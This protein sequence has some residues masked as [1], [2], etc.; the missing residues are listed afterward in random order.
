[1]V[2]KLLGEYICIGLRLKYNK[3]RIT[4]NHMYIKNPVLLNW[5]TGFLYVLTSELFF[6]LYGFIHGIDRSVFLFRFH[7]SKIIGNS[8]SYCTTMPLEF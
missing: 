4:I 7:V 8:E 2:M 5:G 3:L 1:M 6:H